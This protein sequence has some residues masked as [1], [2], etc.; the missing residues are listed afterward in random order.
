MNTS[1]AAWQDW[2]SY[3]ESRGIATVTASL[4]EAV[5]PLSI[6]FAQVLFSAQPVLTGLFPDRQLNA[7]TDLLENREE[8]VQFVSA[9]KEA[10]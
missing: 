5:A 1:Q 8:Y 4:L 3:L 6:P 2:I 10:C 9:L 7:L